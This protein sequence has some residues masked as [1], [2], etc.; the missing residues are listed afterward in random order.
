MT[1]HHLRVSLAATVGRA[2]ARPHLEGALLLRQPLIQ[3]LQLTSLALRLGSG[4]I[5]RFQL[6]FLSLKWLGG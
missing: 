1:A 5:R 3:L 2:P 4:T 6:A